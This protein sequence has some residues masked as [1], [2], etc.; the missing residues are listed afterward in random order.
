MSVQ[1]SVEVSVCVSV[2]FQYKVSVHLY[3]RDHAHPSDDQPDDKD[4]IDV[5]IFLEIRQ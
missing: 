2:V 4:E 5:P 1:A 3:H